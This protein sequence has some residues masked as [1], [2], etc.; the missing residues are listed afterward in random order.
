MIHKNRIYQI[1]E[2]VS[3]VASL[4]EYLTEHSWTLCTAFKLVTAPDAIPLLFLNDAF[5]EDGA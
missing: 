4:A 5:S 1:I 2:E 3:D